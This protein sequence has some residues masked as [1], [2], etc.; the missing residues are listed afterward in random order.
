MLNTYMFCY[1]IAK[2]CYNIN[3]TLRGLTLLR[4]HG[5]ECLRV[6]TE[7]AELRYKCKLQ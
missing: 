3:I 1:N 5:N 6:D 4:P 2:H 7:R